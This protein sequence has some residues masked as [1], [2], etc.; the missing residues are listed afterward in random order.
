[1]AAVV[2]LQATLR[3]TALGVLDRQRGARVTAERAGDLVARRDV[4][5]AVDL[6]EVVFDRAG[7]D[8]EPGADLGVGEAVAGEPRDLRLSRGELIRRF[9]TEF[10]DGLAGG[11]Q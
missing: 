11:L 9:D 7:A 4:E 8:E 2:G 1:M 3:P 10:A 6:V 5:L